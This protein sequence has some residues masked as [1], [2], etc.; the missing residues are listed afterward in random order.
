MCVHLLQ[1][2]IMVF[3][4]LHLTNKQPI[5]NTIITNSYHVL[6][7]N[8]FEMYILECALFYKCMLFFKTQW[9]E[10]QTYYHK[11]RYRLSLCHMQGYKIS[12]LYK[13]DLKL[14]LWQQ[15]KSLDK[16]HLNDN[17]TDLRFILLLYSHLNSETTL[18]A[19]KSIHNILS[20]GYK[21]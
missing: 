13:N 4:R 2:L 11:K 16:L 15:W 10:V 20:N 5:T 1:P 7:S 14:D 3:V 6:H 9:L 18:Y 12:C 8:S 21:L 19:V 17:K